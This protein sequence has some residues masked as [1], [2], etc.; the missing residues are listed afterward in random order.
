MPGL[1]RFFFNMKNETKDTTDKFR[2]FD[3]YYFHIATSQLSAPG[4]AKNYNH[5]GHNDY[6][7]SCRAP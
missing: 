3:Y 5:Q 6:E 2:T 1:Q 7:Q 4:T